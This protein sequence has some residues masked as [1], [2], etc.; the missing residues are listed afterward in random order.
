MLKKLFIFSLI[1]YPLINKNL[2]ILY[3]Y[4]KIDKFLIILDDIMWSA[5][6]FEKRKIWKLYTRFGL[7]IEIKKRIIWYIKKDRE[8][9]NY[10]KKENMFFL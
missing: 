4:K 7:K 9:K 6:E 1:Y 2:L 3:I 5:T 8:Q 10:A